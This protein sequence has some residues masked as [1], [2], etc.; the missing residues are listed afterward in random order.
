MRVMQKYTKLGDL[1]VA[2]KTQSYYEKKTLL[3]PF[4]DAAAIKVAL[5][6]DAGAGRRP[7]EF[8]DNSLIQEIVKEG[9]VE[10]LK[11]NIR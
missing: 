4:T 5:P 9:F 8:F 11:K 6:A 1:E 10:Q 7:E 2:A 3:V